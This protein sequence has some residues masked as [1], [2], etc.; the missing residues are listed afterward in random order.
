[1][2]AH[3]EFRRIGYRPKQIFNL[4]AEVEK[5]PAFLPL[6]R[7]ARISQRSVN[8][9][10]A[11]VYTTDQILQI[12]PFRKRF[13]THTTLN[14][15]HSIHIAS[16]DSLFRQFSIDW[17]FLAEKKNTCM[18]EFEL[19]CVA[20]SP[21]LRPVFDIALLDAAHTIISAFEERAR[22]IYTNP[23]D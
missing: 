7:E 19:N 11:K 21:L 17:R 23:P 20:T 8:S 4:V 9:T 16:T 6:W 14:S 2:V 13:R 3:K 18:I 22:N 10:G 1:M 5:Y 15:P 12:G